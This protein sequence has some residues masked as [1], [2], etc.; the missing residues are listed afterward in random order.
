MDPLEVNFVGWKS[1]SGKL[2]WT[3]APWTLW[4]SAL[5]EPLPPRRA[6]WGGGGRGSA[7]CPPSGSHALTS[8]TE[9][10]SANMREGG[11]RHP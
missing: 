9:P 8:D 1:R 11:I 7:R 2:V 4:A 5:G 6:S 3:K 10:L